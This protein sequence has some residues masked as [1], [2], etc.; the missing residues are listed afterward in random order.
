MFTN[1]AIR[2]CNTYADLF[3]FAG[4]DKDK[5]RKTASTISATTWR[6]ERG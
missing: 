1:V 4:T 2:K 5:S 6:R 3:L